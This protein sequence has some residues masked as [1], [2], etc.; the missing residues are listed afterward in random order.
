[1]SVLQREKEQEARER[2]VKVQMDAMQLHMESLMKMVESTKVP[3]VVKAVSE[4]S[5]VKLVRLTERD[6]IKAYLVT[7]ESIMQAHKIDGGR[8]AHF[9]APPLTGRA[10]LAFAAHPSADSADH[11]E[12]K[13]AILQTCCNRC[14]LTS[15]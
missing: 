8:W 9:L 15:I 1:M 5:G 2:V 4:S 7:L 3:S 6:D 10:Q 13:K 14:P 11:N 12:I